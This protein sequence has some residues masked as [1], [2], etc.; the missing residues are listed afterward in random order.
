MINSGHAVSP[1]GTTERRNVDGAVA[2][3]RGVVRV[4]ALQWFS[5]PFQGR[6]HAIV[7]DTR[8]DE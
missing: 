6:V 7:N 1:A 2:C 8:R 4:R 3:M 5:R